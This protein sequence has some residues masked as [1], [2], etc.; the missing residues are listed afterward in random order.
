MA[1]VRTRSGSSLRILLVA[2]YLIF[3]LAFYHLPAAL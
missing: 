3:A 1:Y 2:V